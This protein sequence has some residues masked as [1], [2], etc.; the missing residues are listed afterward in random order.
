VTGIY[1]RPITL[2]SGKFA[3]IQR[4]DHFT[5]VQWRDI[6]E[7]FRGREVTGIVRGVGVSWKLGH[8]LERTRGLSR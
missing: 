4:D 2:A 3:V 5:I 8:G 6:L 7:R 1:R